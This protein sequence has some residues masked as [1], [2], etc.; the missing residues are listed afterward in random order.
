VRR[1]AGVVLAVLAAGCG[2]TSAVTHVPPPSRHAKPALPPPRA[3]LVTVLDGNTG[4]R[5]HGAVVHEIGR[6]SCRERV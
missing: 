6:A 4:A 1:F 2:S 3:V 5:V